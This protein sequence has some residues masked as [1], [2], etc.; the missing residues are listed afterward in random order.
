[1]CNAFLYINSDVT[2]YCRHTR[3]MKRHPEDPG[4]AQLPFCSRHRSR[5]D[6]RLGAEDNTNWR[7]RRGGPAMRQM[8]M[9]TA[10]QSSHWI[11]VP[12]TNRRRHA[13]YTI[14]AHVQ[15]RRASSAL[16]KAPA[17]GAAHKWLITY[18]L[19]EGH[20]KRDPLECACTQS[21]CLVTRWGR[22][23]CRWLQVLVRGAREGGVAMS[24]VLIMAE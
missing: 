13:R 24:C 19:G 9:R 3:V 17:I 4:S 21:S 23:G 22:T 14:A 16:E 18:T 15:R 6:S 1:M 12:H 10:R 5:L 2:L 7:P 8:L 20:T 11:S